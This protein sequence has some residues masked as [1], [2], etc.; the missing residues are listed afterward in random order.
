MDFYS[1]VLY[2]RKMCDIIDSPG[3]GGPMPA[4][5]PKEPIKRLAIDLPET[6]HYELRHLALD[7]RT[8][9]TEIIRKLVEQR[10]QRKPQ[11][12]RGAAA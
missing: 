7:E 9:V 5:T 2:S 4:T 8:T 6:L 3:G 1:E 10:L 12:K 11:H